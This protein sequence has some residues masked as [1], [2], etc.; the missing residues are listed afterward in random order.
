VC[1][2]YLVAPGAGYS[3]VMG[4][5]RSCYVVCARPETLVP[6]YQALLS[7]PPYFNDG[8]KW[9]QF[10]AETGRFAISSREEAAT[11]EC[12][13]VMVLEVADLA[14]AERQITALG[15]KVL[16]TRDMGAHGRTVTFA[17]P[18]GNVCQLFAGLDLAGLD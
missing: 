11:A 14:G 4:K 2:V 18:A 13:T 3:Q 7:T 8:D 17:D 1:D 10:P 6:F 9:I 16:S 5:I 15:G 12:S